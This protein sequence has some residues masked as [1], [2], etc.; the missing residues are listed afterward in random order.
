MLA[1]GID[2][3]RCARLWLPP[4]AV[5]ANIDTAQRK[6]L[7]TIAKSSWV[8]LRPCCDIPSIVGH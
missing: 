7:M 6:D 1:D 8:F 4:S 2:P 3:P 5:T